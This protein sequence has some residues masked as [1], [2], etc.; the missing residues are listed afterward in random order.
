MDAAKIAE[1]Q[2]LGNRQIWNDVR[3]LMDDA[4]SKSVGIGG[5]SKR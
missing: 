3:L 1:K 5:R 2:V 4:N